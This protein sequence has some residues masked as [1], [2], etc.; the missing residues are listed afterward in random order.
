M[1][2]IEYL[3]EGNYLGLD[4]EKR[5]IRLGIK[6][7]L[8]RELMR[9]KSPQFVVSGSFEFEKFSKRPDFAIA[10]SLFTHLVES[11]IR[12][13]LEK[14]RRFI[15]P[16]GRFYAT[17]FIADGSHVKP[18]SSRSHSHRGFQYPRAM[19]ENFGARAGWRPKYIG[20]WGHPVNQMMVEYVA[21]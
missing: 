15:N 18:G 12:L 11:D 6:K 2:F 17:Y 21:E 4:S 16:G 5:L 8:G 19:V 3:E 9:R 1:K 14:M 13:C 20:D 10:Q 7:E